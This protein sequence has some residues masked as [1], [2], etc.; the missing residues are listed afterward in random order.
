MA[1]KLPVYLLLDTS[2]SMS[3]QPIE[4]VKNGVQML[5]SAL[6]ADPY[7]LET[8]YLSVIT[9][10]SAAKV[11]V[12]LTELTAFQPPNL[13]ASGTTALGAGLTL[14]ADCALRDVV[15]TTATQ[16][17][18][19]KPMVFLMSDGSPTD[20][21]MK[22]LSR[23]RMEKWGIVI[24]CAVDSADEKVLKTVAG[25]ECV[26]RLNTSNSG[27]MAAFFKWVTASVSA[28]SK[29]V[30]TAGKEVTGLDQLPPPP[31]EIQIVT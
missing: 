27:S 26:V 1:R 18:D 3:G 5:V 15:K 28:S 6:R 22:G 29:S 9:F 8:A 2:G 21:W 10:D 16:R 24:A 7:A 17:G 23:F 11:A 25:E 12:P 13:A 14:L 30:E 31:P 19:W 20:D 4:Q